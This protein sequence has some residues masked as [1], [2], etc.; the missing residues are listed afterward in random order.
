MNKKQKSNNDSSDSEE[1]TDE[2]KTIKKQESNNDSSDSEE[3]I[4]NERAIKK[5]SSKSQKIK[6]K[7]SKNNSQ[8]DSEEN[9]MKERIDGYTNSFIK[10]KQKAEYDVFEYGKWKKFALSFKSTYPEVIAKRYVYVEDIIDI[11][12]IPDNDDW[13]INHGMEVPEWIGPKLS[14]LWVPKIF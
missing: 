9:E 14:A 7:I 5:T 3:D 1:N 8:L 13:W 2:E 11:Y 10:I 6:R 12:G 4:D